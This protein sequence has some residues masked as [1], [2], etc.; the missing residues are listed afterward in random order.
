MSLRHF[1][2]PF[3]IIS[4]KILCTWTGFIYR[5][6][7]FELSTFHWGE[8][9]DWGEIPSAPALP[10]HEFSLKGISVDIIW[11]YDNYTGY[12]SKND[13]MISVWRGPRGAQNSTLTPWLYIKLQAPGTFSHLCSLWTG[14][15]ENFTC[16]LGKLSSVQDRDLLMRWA[17]A[18]LMLT[19]Q[20]SVWLECQFEQ[21]C[22]CKSIFM[23]G[24]PF[25]LMWCNKWLCLH[26][27][28]RGNYSLPF[29]P[30]GQIIE[31]TY[32]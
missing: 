28:T 5:V 32:F 21:L 31:V 12:W 9:E 27:W 29:F 8:K 16:S 19:L 20:F 4:V 22:G 23:D 3:L 17:S 11:H 1:S 24:I 15:G 25:L 6:F 10:S 18:W 2:P 30:L 26:L 7:R 14:F 13:N